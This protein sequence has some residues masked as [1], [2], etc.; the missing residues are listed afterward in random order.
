S[1][2]V[3]LVVAPLASRA[4]AQ[5]PARAAILLAEDR[6]APTPRDVAVLRTGA[7]SRNPETARV[8]VRAMGR[9]ERPELIPDIL[10]LLRSPFPE[11]RAEAADAAGQAAQ[12]WK[13]PAPHGA[14]RV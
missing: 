4:A 11:V 3:F 7:R 5:P 6:R 9:L 13:Q 1:V 10:A 2:V 14:A 8:A 12:G